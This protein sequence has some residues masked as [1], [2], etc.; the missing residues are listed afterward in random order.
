DGQRGGRAGRTLDGRRADLTVQMSAD[1]QVDAALL[2]S[3][4]GRGRAVRGQQRDLAVLARGA[5][6][7]LVLLGDRLDVVA[8]VAVVAGGQAGAARIAL[9]EDPHAFHLDRLPVEDEEVLPLHLL[10]DV[11]AGVVVAGDGDDRQV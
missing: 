4:S 1:R 7:G 6:Q 9:A 3:P 10:T 8:L 2:E 11:P 5:G